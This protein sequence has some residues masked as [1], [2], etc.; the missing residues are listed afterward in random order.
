MQDA[1]NVRDLKLCENYT[2]CHPYT[3]RHIWFGTS[4]CEHRIKSQEL[5]S[6]NMWADLPLVP[7]LKRLK[8]WQNTVKSRRFSLFL[9]RVP[10]WYGRFLGHW[11]DDLAEIVRG[12]RA[13]VWLQMM[14]ISSGCVVICGA[15][16]EKPSKIDDFCCFW[17][18]LVL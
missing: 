7:N 2:L 1:D 10:R 18:P 5:R 13:G 11:R 15:A 14:Q 8:N 6:A 9:A 17:P 4:F 12:K 16:A 3:G